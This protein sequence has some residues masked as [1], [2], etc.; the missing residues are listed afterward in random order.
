[1]GLVALTVDQ[2]VYLTDKGLELADAINAQTW[3]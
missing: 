2:R 3:N 1:M